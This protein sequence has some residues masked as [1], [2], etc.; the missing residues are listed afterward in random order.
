MD[1]NIGKA[2]WIGI[3]ILFFIAVVSLGLSMLD[4]GRGIAQQQ[5]DNLSEVQQR[6]ADAQFDIYDNQNVS[7]SQVLA[8]IKSFREMSDTFSIE[9][10]TKKGTNTYLNSASFSGTTVTLGAAI[11]EDAIETSIKNA[12]DEAAAEFINPIAKF[13]AQIRK[14][15]NNVVAGIVFVQE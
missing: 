8:A 4:Q 13:D 14:D 11:A 6:L 7:G 3:G 1:N 15:S 10:T 2:L 5:S 12:R 9:V